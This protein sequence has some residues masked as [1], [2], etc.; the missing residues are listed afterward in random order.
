MKRDVKR[1]N[2]TDLLMLVSLVFER[3]WDFVVYGRDFSG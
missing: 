2:F 3:L 1:V